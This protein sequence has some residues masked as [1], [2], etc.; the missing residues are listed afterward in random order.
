MRFCWVFFFFFFF[1]FLHFVF[2]FFFFSFFF[3]FFFSF[4]FLSFF[5]W[6]TQRSWLGV[7]Y[8]LTNCLFVFSE[9]EL[10][11]TCAG[12]SEHCVNGTTCDPDTKICVTEDGK[13]CLYAIPGVLSIPFLRLCPTLSR[14]PFAS[15]CVYLFTCPYLFWH[16]VQLLQRLPSLSIHVFPERAVVYRGCRSQGP[17]CWEPSAT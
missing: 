17:L 15:F 9:R 5:S 4:F 7:K 10:N 2:F 3:F 14:S 6:C 16:F 8:Q 11:Q 12:F 13:C 1:F